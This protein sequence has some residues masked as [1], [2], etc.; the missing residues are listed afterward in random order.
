MLGRL[1]RWDRPGS[2]TWTSGRKQDE[3]SINSKQCCTL[4]AAAF[5]V[6]TRCSVAFVTLWSRMLSCT[7]SVQYCRS[8]FEFVVGCFLQVSY[9]LPIELDCRT[10]L[11]QLSTCCRATPSL[12]RRG[13]R[14]VWAARTFAAHGQVGQNHGRLGKIRERQAAKE[15]RMFTLRMHSR[16]WARAKN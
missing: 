13:A 6:G 11:Q 12:A 2:A 8:I 1:Q 9:R 4:L 10:C 7:V 15:S 16:S 3:T 14:V 5:F